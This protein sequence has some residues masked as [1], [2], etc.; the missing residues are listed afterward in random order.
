MSLYKA[1]EFITKE[2]DKK[3]VFVVLNGGDSIG[4]FSTVEEAK[5][6]IDIMKDDFSTNAE[7]RTKFAQ[8]AETFLDLTKKSEEPI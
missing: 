6:F 2:V 1:T 8:H 7:Y 3:V 5:K 4:E